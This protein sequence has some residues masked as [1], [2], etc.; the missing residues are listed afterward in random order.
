[1]PLERLIGPYVS[2][3]TACHDHDPVATDVARRVAALIEPA[4]PGVVVEHIGSTA[5]PGCP[6]KGVV[7]LML[8]YPDGHLAAA[9]DLLDALGFQRQTGRDP[10]PEERPMRVGSLDHAGTTFLLHVH[11]IAASSSEAG[12]LRTFRDRLRADPSLVD[13]YVA[14]K[15]AILQAG[16]TD[17]VDYCNHK[18]QFIQAASRL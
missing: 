13:A 1:M 2:Q 17:P 15:R 5:V 6:G 4:L 10:F 9:R 14:L 8:L 12:L 11:V 16:V 7:D 3:P 18:D